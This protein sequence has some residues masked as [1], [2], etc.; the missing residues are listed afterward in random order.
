MAVVT[1]IKNHDIM[2]LVR[3]I[4]DYIYELAVSQSQNSPVIHPDD[5]R[6]LKEYLE[7]S[8]FYKAWVITQPRID[9]PATHPAEIPVPNGPTERPERN[10]CL[11]DVI[12]MFEKMRDEL[13]QCVSAQW[14]AGLAEDDALRFDKIHGKL[15]N[16]VV[17]F[18]E[19]TQPVDQPEPPSARN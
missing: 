6:R 7:S 11:I 1:A 16:Y 4:N 14:A 15:T 13:L 2:G 18:I 3:R 19:Q 12:V 10:N 8:A 5:L 17:D 9:L